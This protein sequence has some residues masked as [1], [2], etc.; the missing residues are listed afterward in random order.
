MG[1][2]NASSG[3]IAISLASCRLAD[4]LA[5]LPGS[6]TNDKWTC[7]ARAANAGR[8]YTDLNCQE[9][10]YCENPQATPDGKCAPRKA[11]GMACNTE[12]ECTSFLCKSSKCGAADDVQAA[13]C[14]K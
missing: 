7:A 9:G 6:N 2:F 8:C 5:C 14:Y 10:L 11:T 13:Y 1:G 12:T 4:G 3:D